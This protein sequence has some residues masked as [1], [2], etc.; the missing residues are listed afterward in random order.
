M[1]GQSAE[2]HDLHAGVHISFDF[3]GSPE[4][5]AHIQ[6]QTTQLIEGLGGTS[7]RQAV[8][9]PEAKTG[10]T[11]R[12]LD[13]SLEWLLSGISEH[14]RPVARGS[15]RSEGVICARDILM[16]GLRTLG[17]FT[18]LGDRTLDSMRINLSQ[19]LPL[20][21]FKACPEI[22]DVAALC[23]RPDQVP[24]QAVICRSLRNLRLEPAAQGQRVTLA[25]AIYNTSSFQLLKAE[26]GSVSRIREF[27]TELAR[28]K[29]WPRRKS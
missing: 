26:A 9:E 5:L 1:T 8:G 16:I 27:Y 13:G 22:E 7:V 19:E 17:K 18:G 12:L 4:Q 10:D 15:F 3:S 29:G 11:E 23:L 21:P 20:I 2:S 14:A 24:L 28:L 6:E 25:D